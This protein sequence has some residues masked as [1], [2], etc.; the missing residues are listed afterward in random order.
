MACCVVL[1]SLSE[2][3]GCCACGV[4]WVLR[5]SLCARACER[6]TAPLSRKESKGGAGKENERERSSSDRSRASQGISASGVCVCV[7][8][9]V[10]RAGWAGGEGACCCGAARKGRAA[11][12][13]P[14][15]RRPSPSR[16]PAA[17]RPRRVLSP[18]AHLAKD[19]PS[20][21]FYTRRCSLG[22]TS[23][24]TC[25][26]TCRVEFCGGVGRRSDGP[27]KAPR[28]PNEKKK[29]TTLSPLLFTPRPSPA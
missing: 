21:F 2:G 22:L 1:F 20:S 11:A 9:S 4:C 7:C 28:A 12:G 13:L 18:S 8:G 5:L 27:E 15:C 19:V 24:H 26:H 3:F 17:A 16:P 14:R 29:I 10:M 25:A 6:E 23:R